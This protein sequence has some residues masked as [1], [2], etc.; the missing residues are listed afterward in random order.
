MRL[1]ADLCSRTSLCRSLL[2]SVAPC[3]LHTVGGEEQ[4]AGLLRQ[5]EPG[6]RSNALISATC[7]ATPRSS[8]ARRRIRCLAGLSRLQSAWAR[9]D[10]TSRRSISRAL[11]NR[12]RPL[13]CCK[14]AHY[15]ANCRARRPRLRLERRRCVERSDEAMATARVAL[16]RRGL[17]FSGTSALTRFRRP[18]AARRAP[19][20]RRP[21][22]HA[23]DAAA[24]ERLPGP[25]ARATA[26]GG[27]SAVP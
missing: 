23:A 12:P 26:R 6:P 16:Q 18:Q 22:R 27:A 8:R 11:E 15:A 14:P 10:A 2:R 5:P 9:R 24:A 19:D 17:I 13:R 7:A 21:C 1:L 25:A 4:T 20:L 3:S